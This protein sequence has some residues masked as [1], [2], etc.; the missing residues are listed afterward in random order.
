MFDKR[1][2]QAA[3]LR[4]LFRRAPPQVVA[5]YACG[6]HRSHNAV[7]AAHR[8]AGHAERVLIL[9]EAE[10]EVGLATALQQT[11]GPDLLQLLDGRTTL[12]DVLQPAPGL[13]GRVSAVAAA[14]AAA[15][16]SA[17]SDYVDTYLAQHD[18][19]EEG[20]DEA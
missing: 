3:G 8:I 15:I 11:P 10:G 7:L 12:A 16:N 1:E 4:R 6:R 17:G 5:L 20:S 19:I 18:M 14:L 2:D 13:M 9:D